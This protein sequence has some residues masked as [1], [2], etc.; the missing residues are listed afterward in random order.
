MVIG[1]T[2]YMAATR[3]WE[4][5]KSTYRAQRVG[6]MR[7]ITRQMILSG[8]ECTTYQALNIIDAI[9]Q[10]VLLNGITK[11]LPQNEQTNRR[12]P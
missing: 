7:Q 4:K 9:I 11:E 3:Q 5:L 10:V 2:I 6:P 12:V 8:V 1:E